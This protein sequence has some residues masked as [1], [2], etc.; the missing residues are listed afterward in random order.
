VGSAVQSVWRGG[1]ASAL[2]PLTLCWTEAGLARLSLPAEA[3][4]GGEEAWWRRWFGTIRF[5]TAEVP[6]AWAEMLGS[7]LA[8]KPGRLDLPLDLRGT[9]FQLEVWKLLCQIPYG[10]VI[11][12]RELA[13]RSSRPKGYRAVG[14]ANGRNPVPIVVPCHR[15]VAADGT[16]GG[17]SGG[18]PTKERLLRLEKV[19]VAQWC[20]PVQMDL[21]AAVG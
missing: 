12:Y 17:Y 5:E 8:G 6:A 4:G 14:A 15:V 7:Y 11:S 16:I 3:P 19:P 10:G 21:F 2:G 1:L 18:L 20:K 9:A 13:A